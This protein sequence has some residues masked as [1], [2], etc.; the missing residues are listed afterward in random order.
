MNGRYPL[1]MED[2]YNEFEYPEG[3]DLVGFSY[4][5]E[6]RNRLKHGQGKITYPN[7]NIFQGIFEDDEMVLGNFSFHDESNPCHGDIYEGGF[8]NGTFNGIGTYH[9]LSINH[10]TPGDRYE[11]SFK[12]GKRHGQGIYYY[13]DGSTEEG[14]WTENWLSGKGKLTFRSGDYFE[15]DLDKGVPCGKGA[16]YWSNGEIYLGNYS[17]GE[18][19]GMGCYTF[20]DRTTV[21]GNFVSGTIEGKQIGQIEHKWCAHTIE[22]LIRYSM[23][24]KGANREARSNGDDF[25]YALFAALKDRGQELIREY[26]PPG[27]RHVWDAYIPSFPRTVI[28][29]V[30][31]KGLLSVKKQMTTWRN[32]VAH[33]LIPHQDLLICIRYKWTETQ[34]NESTKLEQVA[35]ELGIVLL[36]LPK[37]NSDEELRQTAMTAALQIETLRKSK[38]NVVEIDVEKCQIPKFQRQPIENPDLLSS[39]KDKGILEPITVIQEADGNYTIIDGGSRLSIARKIGMTTIPAIQL[40]INLGDFWNTINEDVDFDVR[41][42][43]K[44]ELMSLMSLI[45]EE[46]VRDVIEHEF[47]QLTKEYEENHHTSCGLRVGRL[48]ELL[49]YGLSSTWSVSLNEPRLNGLAMI[50]DRT[51]EL[52]SMFLDYCDITDEEKRNKKF[53]EIQGKLNKIM[54]HIL[55]LQMEVQKIDPTN[56]QSVPRNTG[57]I[58]RDIKRKYSYIEAVRNEFDGKSLENMVHGIMAIR[59]NAAHADINLQK[60]ELTKSDSEDMIIK[61]RELMYKLSNI[62]NAIQSENN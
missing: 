20:L 47:V 2:G 59:N 53:E 30:E 50:D 55:N 31:G 34:E 5:G 33:S 14:V 52:K 7:G 3:H 10:D 40:D 58:L 61:I 38:V 48:L 32:L 9:Y 23:K 11:G 26:R 41:T 16:Y 12:D 35:E 22:T 29:I 37:P 46:T 21:E 17:K 51:S 36:N 28:E 4:A 6:V 43:L 18:R 8:E 60:R 15:G 1:S 56:L 42:L 25:I 57:A 13:H 27:T 44:P 24:L 62:G 49:I 45:H 39:I 19:T 54:Q